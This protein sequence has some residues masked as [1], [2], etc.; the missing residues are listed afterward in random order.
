MAENTIR[1][2]IVA[3]IKRLSGQLN[4]A[5]SKIQNF[6]KR[7]SSVG[8]GLQ[9][10]LA[11]PIIAAGGSAIKMA[12][13]FDK[14]LT[15]IQSLVGVAAEDVQAMG[16]AARTMAAETGKSANEAA[17]ALF[18]ITSAGLRGSDAMD[19]LD[20]SLKASAVGLGETRIVA[21]LATSAMNAFGK[22]NLSATDATD[23]LVAAVR[24]GKLSSEELAGAMGSVLPIAS[25]MGVSFN[26]VGAAFAAMSR[27]GTNAAFASTQLRGI[28]K[29]LLSPSKQ[30]EETLNSLGLSSVGLRKSIREDGLL[31]TLEI[32]KTNFEGNDQATQ[33]VFNNTKALTGIM[34]LLGKGVDSTRQ[35]FG[36]MED[37]QNDTAEAF[38]VL[39]DKASF[40]LNKALIGIKN[41][42][43]DVG[44]VLLTALLPA[45]QKVS[46][47]VKN[48]VSAFQNLST[49]QKGIA[50]GLAGLAAAL[51]TILTIGGGIITV[52]G[53]IIS[54]IGLIVAGVAAV[55][56]IIVKNWGAVRTFLVDFANYFIDLYNESFGFRLVVESIFQ[57]FKTLAQIAVLSFETIINSFKIL[58]KFI[59]DTGAGLG[60]VLEGIFTLDPNKIKEGLSDV[61]T[62]IKEGFNEQFENVKGTIQDIGELASKNFSEGYEK[63]LKPQIIGNITETAF[64]DGIDG[65]VSSLKN[66]ATS[67]FSNVFGTINLPSLGTTT[68]SGESGGGGEFDP[69]KKLTEKEKELAKKRAEFQANAQSF[70]EGMNEIIQQGISNIVD[71]IAGALENAIVSGGNLAKGLS[72]ALLGNI[73]QIAIDLGKMAIKIGLAIKAID[74]GLKNLNPFVAIAAGLALV[75]LGS[76]FKKGASQIAGGGG[77]GATKF[78]KGG[79]VSAP[80]L[81]L[82]GEYTGA[83]SNPEVIA[84]LD[85]LK[86]MIQPQGGSNIN[87]GGSFEVRGQDLVLA[88]ERANTNRSRII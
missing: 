61:G 49:Q 76:M 4:K 30:A 88:L 54:P 15:Q 27:T 85:K 21:D 20:A 8:A 38:G 26:E 84:P 19:V 45:F 13:D 55:A 17:Q 79:I 77:G 34:D 44:S 47:F 60:K 43:T 7:M 71:G 39:S 73:G 66:K 72:V 63:A 68:S 24:E 70:N 22:E 51:P 12:F 52:L 37:V 36:R 42:L 25:N 59:Y 11:L 56:A 46:G 16:V 78:A 86:T 1:V 29:T 9:S 5:S 81:G 10:R 2:N 57:V 83:R 69:V 62:A 18:F 75:A 41:S 35:I 87:V 31:A 23:V 3:D 48:V 6:G 74:L 33:D 82:V 40:Q 32:L 28:L 58:G 53:A 67:L 14:S 64:Q 65:I 80:T 50:I